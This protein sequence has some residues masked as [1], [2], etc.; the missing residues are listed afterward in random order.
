M[1]LTA[2]S[3]SGRIVSG[4]VILFLVFDGVT[5]LLK[6]QQVLDAQTRLGY[7]ARLAP[8]LGTIVLVCTLL[9]V[10]PPVSIFG[11]ILLTGYLGG[12]V[13]SQLRIG[14]PLFD[15]CF[16]IFFGILAW[17]GLYLRDEQLRALIP[18]RR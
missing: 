1:Q 9:Y 4:L 2:M 10:I 17:A 15:N 8:V 3:W 7:P 12:A 11:A 6:V 16:P 13:A 5:K 14:A 18:V